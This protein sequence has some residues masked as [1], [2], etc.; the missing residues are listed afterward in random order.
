MSST[1]FVDFLVHRTTPRSMKPEQEVLGLRATT[2]SAPHAIAARAVAIGGAASRD[3]RKLIRKQRRRHRPWSSCD[4]VG[5]LPHPTA[6][7]IIGGFT[8][9]VGIST[10]ALMR[11]RP[12]EPNHPVMSS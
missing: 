11:S 6:G 9:I 7:R 8:M 5:D 12:P 10:F 1:S 2:A 4:D 3:G